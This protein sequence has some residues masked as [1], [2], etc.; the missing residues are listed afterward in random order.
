MSALFFKQA[1]DISKLKKIY[2]DD[3]A[4]NQ[5][6]QKEIKRLAAEN[7]SIRSNLFKGFNDVEVKSILSMTDEQMKEANVGRIIF[8]RHHGYVLHSSTSY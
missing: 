6:L 5:K 7:T 8:E 4:E 3:N 2:A 1:D